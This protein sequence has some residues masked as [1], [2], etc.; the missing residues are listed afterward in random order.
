MEMFDSGVN[1]YAIGIPTDDEKKQLESD[2]YYLHSNGK[3]ED[4]KPYEIWVK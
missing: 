4:K 1:K 3:T 2:G